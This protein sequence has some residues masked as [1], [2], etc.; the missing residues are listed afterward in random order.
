[1]LLRGWWTV[2]GL[3]QIKDR[4]LRINH[5]FILMGYVM[6]EALATAAP[7]RVKALRH[8]RTNRIPTGV[9]TPS[10]VSFLLQSVC[11]HG[12]NK[13]IPNTGTW[14]SGLPLRIQLHSR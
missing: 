1:M 13:T 5:S 11:Q 2:S 9:Q 8:S 10:V 6:I 12:I 4:V 14:T 3:G 7:F